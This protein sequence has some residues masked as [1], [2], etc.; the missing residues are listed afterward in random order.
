[1]S[2]VNG[3]GTRWIIGILIPLAV[4]IG[5]GI[6]GWTLSHHESDMLEAATQRGRNAE[7]IR[8]VS[9]RTATLEA[10]MG[11]LKANVRIIGEDGKKILARMP[12]GG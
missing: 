6:A 9:E 4:V 3:N 5:C 10:H 11:N 7:H 1:M 2:W 8:I 12:G